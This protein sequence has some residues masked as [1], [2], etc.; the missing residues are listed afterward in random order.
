MAVYT[1]YIGGL[2]YVFSLLAGWLYG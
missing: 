1:A 2:D